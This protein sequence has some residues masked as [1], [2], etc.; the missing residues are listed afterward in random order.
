MALPNVTFDSTKTV[1][2]QKSYAVFT[3]TGGTAINLVG[4]LVNYDQTLDTIKREIPGADGL[5]R[6]DRVVGIRHTETFKLETEDVKR[7]TEIFGALAG[8]KQGTVALY[9][10]DPKDASGK[11][12]LLTNTFACTATLDGGLAFQNGEFS[13]ATISFEALE[14]V[15]F[16]ADANV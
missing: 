1:V 5:L 12:S 4:K 13:K 16:T 3:P 11:C 10:T 6:A 7:L 15:T 2:A 14:K 9:M 8:I